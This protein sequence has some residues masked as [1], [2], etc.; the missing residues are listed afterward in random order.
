M[1]EESRTPQPTR[2]TKAGKER[3]TPCP[4]KSRGK[5]KA[6]KTTLKLKRPLQ[7]I[8]RKK[9]AAKMTTLSIQ[10]PKG[11][12]PKLFGHYHQLNKELQQNEPGQK[13]RGGPQHLK[14]RRDPQHLE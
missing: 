5:G 7:G 12:K 8:L 1:A 9:A 13:G 14:G 10:P 4:P 6:P 3:K 2:N 11:K